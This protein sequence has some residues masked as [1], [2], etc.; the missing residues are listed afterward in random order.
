M[1]YK[2]ANS[3]QLIE[4]MNPQSFSEEVTKF[5]QLGYVLWGETVVHNFESKNGSIS[6]L[7]QQV[8][9]K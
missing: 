6:S 2:I 8:V 7:Y 4:S 9:I 1:E 5:L 3:Y